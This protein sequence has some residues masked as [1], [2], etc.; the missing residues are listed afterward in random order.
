[1]RK[2]HSDN[3]YFCFTVNSTVGNRLLIADFHAAFPQ[4]ISSLSL[5]SHL[6]PGSIVMPGEKLCQVLKEK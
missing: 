1:M 2:Q 6:L 4:L 3:L 5:L